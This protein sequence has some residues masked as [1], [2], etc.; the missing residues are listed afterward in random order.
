MEKP[1]FA[2]DVKQRYYI[3]HDDC[4]D[5]YIA[6]RGSKALGNGG[7]DHIYWIKADTLGLWM[8]SGQINRTIKKLMT[9]VPELKIEQLGDGEAVLSAPVSSLHQLCRTAGA[10]V[11]PQLSDERKKQLTE[12]THSFRFSKSSAIEKEKKA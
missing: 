11:R 8:S 3:R 7:L 5:E 6:L 1:I 10:R 12:Q 2:D 9:Q 4:G